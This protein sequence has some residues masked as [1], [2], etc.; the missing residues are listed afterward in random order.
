MISDIKCDATLREYIVQ[1]LQC[2]SK[3]AR[4]LATFEC[5]VGNPVCIDSLR[6]TGPQRLSRVITAKIMPSARERAFVRRWHLFG[7]ATPTPTPTQTSASVSVQLV[8]GVE[9]LYADEQ[10]LADYVR[11]AYPTIGIP[12]VVSGTDDYIVLKRPCTIASSLFRS[13]AYGE[14]SAY[15]SIPM[16]SRQLVYDLLVRVEQKCANVVY[17]HREFFSVMPTIYAHARQRDKWLLFG[18]ALHS[19]EYSRAHN[20]RYMV[21]FADEPIPLRH[22]Y[23]FDPQSGKLRLLP[24][25]STVLPVVIGSETDPG[26]MHV[27]VKRP[28][29]AAPATR[30]LSRF[31]VEFANALAD[32]PA[33][34]LKTCYLA[35]TVMAGM[36]DARSASF[37]D[38]ADRALLNVAKVSRFFDFDALRNPAEFT[39]TILDAMYTHIIAD[40]TVDAC[41]RHYAVLYRKMKA[42]FMDDNDIASMLHNATMRVIYQLSTLYFDAY[43]TDGQHVM[44]LFV[45]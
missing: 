17:W 16:E 10:L 27:V 26:I 22:R 44:S 20:A 33:I 36:L 13:A 43:E 37:I 12:F 30:S 21:R 4:A 19:V 5:N 28:E 39:K 45:Y 15:A 6:I 29:N 9:T 1:Q 3:D 41:Q 24:C 14:D 40:F 7:F 31:A 2:A 11:M 32:V 34:N 38:Q 18:R 8:C 35:P 42:F 23:Y 25:S